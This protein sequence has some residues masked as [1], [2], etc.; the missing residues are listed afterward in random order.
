MKEDG[1]LV[2]LI[3]AFHP[4]RSSEEHHGLGPDEGAWNATVIRNSTQEE[5]GSLEEV[6]L[7]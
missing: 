6:N 4:L 3:I 7:G 1:V 2:R 5:V